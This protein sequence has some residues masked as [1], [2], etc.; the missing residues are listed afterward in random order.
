[1]KTFVQ[2]KKIKKGQ[3]TKLIKTKRLRDDISCDIAECFSCENNSKILSIEHPIIFLTQ[4]VISTQMDAIENF[5][6]IDN[7]VIPQSEYNKLLQTKND[8]ILKKLKLLIEN[9]NFLIFANEYHSEI[10]LIK[11]EE[12]MSKAQRNNIILSNTINF[13]QEHITDI[14]NDFTIYVLLKDENEINSI[15]SLLQN[16][17]SNIKFFDMYSFGKE[18]LKSSPDLFNFIS[19]DINS[20]EEQNSMLIEEEIKNNNSLYE[21]H[22]SEKEM[23]TNIKQGKMYQ[24][25][26]YFQNNILDKAIVKSNLFDKDIVIEGDKNLNRAMHGDIVCFSL[27]EETKWKKDINLKLGEEGDE[28]IEQEDNS[29]DKE[30]LSNITNIKEKISK[31]NLQPTGYIT[32]ILRRNRNIFCGTIYNPNDRINNSINDDLSNFLKN[33]NTKNLSIFIP[34]DSKYPNF[35]LQLY[36]QEKYYNQ[37]IVIKF[38]E[39]KENII[40]PSGH[41]FKNLGQCLVVP[42]ENEIILYEHNVD[43]NPF[44]KKIVDSLPREDVEFKCPP[45]ELKKRMDLRSK[46]VCSIDPPGCKDI[47]DALHA[48]V[49]SNGNYELGVHIADVSH[50]VKSGSVVDK[51]AAKNCNTIYLVHKRTDMLPKVLTENLC[52]LV[53]KKERLAFSVLW[54]FDKDTLE[55]KNV[56]YGK[57][58]IKSLAALE[59]GQAQKILNDPNDN[60]PM[61]MSIKIMDKITRHLKQKRLEA[62]ALI[63][64]SNSM[65]FNLDNETN[66]ITDISEYKT[67]QTNSLVEECMLLA[68]V[69]VAKKIYESFPSCA[70]LR[71]HPPPKEKELNNFIQLLK[72]RGF[73]LKAGN[74]M[75]LNNSLDNINKKGDPFFNKLVRT[76]LTRTMNQA[77]YFPSSEFSY[78]DFYH[79]GLAMEIYTHFTS[80]IRRY[81]DILVHRLLSAALENDYLPMEIANK[82]KMNK[83]CSQMNRQNRVGFFCGQDSNYFSAFTFF[84]EHENKSKNLEVVIHN[85]DENIIKAMS[86]EYGI[87]G[88]LEFDKIGGIENIDP[89]NKTFKLKNGEKVDLFDH[90]ICEIV[91]TFFNYR[92]EIKY[93]YIKKI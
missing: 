39:W 80:P 19:F 58:V 87:E 71:R 70:I 47:D 93:F 3:I 91:T 38:D 14:T 76:L 86:V 72:E 60:S 55:I 89:I 61:A 64:S 83:E 67:Y 46:P 88:N 34:I 18:M 13:F 90:I 11:D 30:M 4:E 73:E 50:Y 74:N 77:K 43:I 23:K 35:I 81:S 49:L 36:E 79:Y 32:G 68:N 57:S 66:T 52:S 44:S 21:K 2:Y 22:L 9:R 27:Y 17:L 6:I 63:L 10:A 8:L 40:I 28:G 1:M 7:C 5:R 16:D 53:G 69:W 42:V 54:E 37:R 31:T 82:V 78:E 85:I 29:H 33:Y 24:G 92:Y 15:K 65:K 48:I 20:K 41:F 26:I 51:I 45:E 59:Y 75:E 56:K 84:K 25:K 62:G 12:K